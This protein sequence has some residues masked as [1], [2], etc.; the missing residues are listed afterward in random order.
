MPKVIAFYLPQFHEIPENN[1]KGAPFKGHFLCLGR[2]GA[3][4]DGEI[5]AGV[6]HNGQSSNEK[7]EILSFDNE[8]KAELQSIAPLDYT[9]LHRSMILDE[10]QAVFK[11]TDRIT[12]IAT[13][14]RLFNVVQH[15][16]VGPPFLSESTIVDCNAGKGFMQ[17]LSYPAPERYEY[18]WPAATVDSVGLHIDLTK[19]DETFSYVSTHLMKDC[20]GWVTAFS[21]E[22]GLMLGYI[23]KTE[24]YPWL[25]IWH[26]RKN[27]KLWAKGLEFGTTGVGRPYQDL[28][29][30]DTRFH[31]MNSFI[32]LDAKEV[33]SKSFICFLLKIPADFAG[34][35]SVSLNDGKIIIIEKQTNGKNIYTILCAFQ[36]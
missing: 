29:A 19:S 30:A 20:I 11:I 7:W 26:Q 6:P 16:T 13:A 10:R 32:Y 12:S 35:E 25:N 27:D 8:R 3:P 21:P 22:S 18:E 28:L 24:E 33:I 15:V 23:W 9:T 31:G 4:T 14:G 1:Q 36:L 34:V 5:L 2:W 17:H